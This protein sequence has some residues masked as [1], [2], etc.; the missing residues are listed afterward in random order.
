MEDLSPRQRDLLEFL[1]STVEQSGVVPS[2]RE[3][4]TALGIGSTN[5]VSDHLKALI[6]KG[7]VERVGEPG[8]PRSLRLTEQATGFI[9]DA[10]LDLFGGFDLRSEEGAY[11]RL[12][13]RRNLPAFGRRARMIDR[14]TQDGFLALEVLDGERAAC[15]DACDIGHQRQAFVHRGQ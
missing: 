7:Y 10:S 13:E 15:L 9:E 3:I 14:G 1:I 11:L 5:A 4:G 6:R 2:Y 12:L 8:R